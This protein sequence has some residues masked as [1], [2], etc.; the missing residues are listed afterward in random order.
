MLNGWDGEGGGADGQPEGAKGAAALETKESTGA[1]VRHAGLPHHRPGEGTGGHQPR[2]QQP[3]LLS[4]EKGGER[5]K[6]EK[7]GVE[8]DTLS[9]VSMVP[10]DT[11]DPSHLL[12]NT[13]ETS[14]TLLF[15]MMEDGQK[16]RGRAAPPH[17]RFYPK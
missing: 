11:G 4:G 9:R 3:R 8:V 10:G 7:G 1:V 12:V 14:I 15:T 16:V 2:P 5:E 17:S 13:M 6:E